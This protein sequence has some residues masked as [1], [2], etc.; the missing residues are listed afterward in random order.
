MFRCFVIYLKESTYTKHGGNPL[1]NTA[2]ELY[3]KPKQ[4]GGNS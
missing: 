2:E 1:D 4:Q 3:G